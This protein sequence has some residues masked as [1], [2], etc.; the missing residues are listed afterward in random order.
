MVGQVEPGTVATAPCS[1]PLAGQLDALV[2]I[3]VAPQL[4]GAVGAQPHVHV[5]SPA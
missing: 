2:I 5:R 3:I 4:A 1:K